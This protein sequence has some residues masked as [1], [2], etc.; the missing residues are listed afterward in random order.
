MFSTAKMEKNKKKLIYA[1]FF[2]VI[3]IGSGYYIHRYVYSFYGNVVK[4]VSFEK[5]K[6]QAEVVD[7]DPKKQKG[8][9]GRG[10]LCEKCGMLF[11]FSERGRHSFWMRG[12]EFPL[13][14]LWIENGRVVEIKKNI[15]LDS[16]EIFYPKA[17][18]DLV[19][20]FA[21]GTVDEFG[22]KTGDVV[23]IE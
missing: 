17:E 10:G 1:I 14:I 20:E 5:G 23:T 7:S 19:L 15:D 2:L 21:A 18:S 22:I 9:G 3:L 4:E 8:L 16:R 11:V 6:F 12:M 13:D